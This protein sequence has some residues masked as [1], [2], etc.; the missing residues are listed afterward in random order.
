MFRVLLTM[1]LL[2]AIHADAW[3]QM[4]TECGRGDKAACVV[5]GDT[6]WLEGHKVRVADIDAPELNSAKC[7]EEYEAALASK[8]RLLQLLNGGTF[9]LRSW[10]GREYDRYGRR[11]AV[12][13]R[14]GSSIG[15]QMVRE[16]YARPWEGKRRPWC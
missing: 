5:D 11:L 1:T 7:R 8:H 16:G 10:V 14:N 9:E 12:V 15:D 6:F 3:A 4:F 13:V 2:C